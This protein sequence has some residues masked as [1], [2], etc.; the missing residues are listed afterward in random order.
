MEEIELLK[1]YLKELE[2]KVNYELRNGS[3]SKL[4]FDSLFENGKVPHVLYRMLPNDFVKIDYQGFMC[5]SG[6][7]SCTTSIDNFI[8][9]TTGEHIACL[10]IYLDSPRRRIV[11]NELVPESND[12]G[13]YILPTNTKLQFISKSTYSD[14]EQFEKLIEK[15]NLMSSGQELKS[16]YGIKSITIY[17]FNIV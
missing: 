11:V 9:H 6:Y 3:K 2:P 12:E 13:E 7:L 4:T 16:I 5:D 1:R 14:E 10:K 15:E 17:E 8:E